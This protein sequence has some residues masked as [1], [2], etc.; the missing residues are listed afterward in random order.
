MSPSPNPERDSDPP[1]VLLF[2]GHRIDDPGR[3]VPRF[4][5]DKANIARTEIGATIDDALARH[6]RNIVG[7]AGAA[8]GGDILFHEEC[9]ARGVKTTIYLALPADDYEAQSVSSS[10]PQWTDAYRDLLRKTRT[11]QLQ[12]ADSLALPSNAD[13]YN[14]WQLTNLWMLHDALAHGTAHMTLI[15]LWNGDAGDGP[16]GTADMVQQVERRGGKVVR[17]GRDTIFQSK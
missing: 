6:G 12:D 3:P 7:I 13:D 15:A 16:G 9:H 17:L 4:P 2:T 1:H 8:S 11:L 10:G 14:V 5:A